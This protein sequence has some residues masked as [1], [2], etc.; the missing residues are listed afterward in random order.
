MEDRFGHSSESRKNVIT[1][2]VT[3]TTG[4]ALGG[5]GFLLMKRPIA[6]E[7]C[8]AGMFFSL[9]TAMYLG[10]YGVGL[11]LFLALAGLLSLIAVF[12]KRLRIGGARPV[13][14]PKREQ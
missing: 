1:F 14:S 13:A 2:W 4:F 7:L 9:A 5:F 11:V 12:W 10:E 8:I 6:C 3:M